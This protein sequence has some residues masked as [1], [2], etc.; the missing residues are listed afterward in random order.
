MAHPSRRAGTAHPW[1]LDIFSIQDKR[2]PIAV[3]IIIGVGVGIGIGIEGQKMGSGHEKLTTPCVR[4]NHNSQS[5]SIP[6]PIPTPTPMGTRSR[7]I[8]NWLQAAAKPN[9]EKIS[10]LQTR[11]VGIAHQGGHRPPDHPTTT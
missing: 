9:D 3:G 8:N 10:K 7:Q 11:R 1:G 2:V 4:T 6:I 5:E